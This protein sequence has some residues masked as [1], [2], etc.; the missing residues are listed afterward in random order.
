MSVRTIADKPADGQARDPLS[1]AYSYPGAKHQLQ[2][3]ITDLA[4]KKDI[5][6]FGIICPNQKLHSKQLQTV[7]GVWLVISLGD[8]FFVTHNSTLEWSHRFNKLAFH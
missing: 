4:P 7:R 6:F 8:F 3:K 5:R 2:Q 1:D